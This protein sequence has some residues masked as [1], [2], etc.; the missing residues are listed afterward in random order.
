M[1]KRLIALL[2]LVPIA[3]VV[4]WMAVTN[5]QPISI[6]FP[7]EIRGEPF[8]TFEVPLYMAFFAT[9]LLGVFIGSF[10]TW[11]K[12]GKHRK[13]ARVQKAEAN[14]WH[15]EA[16]KAKERADDLA[17]KVAATDGNA[18]ASNSGGLGLPSP[19]KAA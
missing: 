11:F 14:K 4:V 2:I 17:Q 3:I 12:Q 8:F 13:A 9:L 10:T 16:D 18:I 7:P 6:A 15:N 19:S 1:L 5:R